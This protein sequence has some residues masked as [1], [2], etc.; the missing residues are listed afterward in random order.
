VTVALA[1]IGVGWQPASAAILTG[2]L[3]WLLVTGQADFA[4]PR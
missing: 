1:V 3:T 2:A 4:S